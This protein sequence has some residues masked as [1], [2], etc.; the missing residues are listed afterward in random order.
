MPIITEKINPATVDID[1]ANG[2][3]IACL[4]NNEDKKVALAIEKI[5]PQIG[6]AIEKI[7]ERMQKGG[8][9]AYFGSGTSGRIGILD[10]S[11]MPPTF[12]AAPDLIQGYISAAIGRFALQWKAPKTMHGWLKMTLPTLMRKPMMWL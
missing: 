11:E 2:E 8:R 12:G 6:M 1:L 9:M 7:A 5:V 10:A 4:I 3:K